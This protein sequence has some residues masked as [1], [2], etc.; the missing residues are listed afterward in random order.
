MAISNPGR[1]IVGVRMVP[2]LS[3]F[4]VEDKVDLDRVAHQSFSKKACVYATHEVPPHPPSKQATELGA[5]WGGP[6][7]N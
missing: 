4:L 5:D 1:N 6:G 3:V 2:V 7:S